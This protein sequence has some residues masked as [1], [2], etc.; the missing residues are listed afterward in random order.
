MTVSQAL[1]LALLQGV[2]ELFPI[3]SLGHTILVPALLHWQNLD[4]SSPPFLAFVVVLHLGTAV[5]LI[6]YYRTEWYAIAR[7]LVGSI[8]RGQLSENRDERIG[9]R[10]VVGTIPVGILGVIFEAPV[11]RLFGSPAP[12]AF[13]LVLNGLVMF[14]GET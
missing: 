7:A 3:S 8:V 10:L 13:F 2:S 9:W 1:A 14:A 6:L 4:R 11:R 12:A 5:A